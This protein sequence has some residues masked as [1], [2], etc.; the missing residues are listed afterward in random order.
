[1]IAKP[2]VQK[3][4][5]ANP[6]ENLDIQGA[7]VDPF[8]D[9]DD[10]ERR[11]NS[12]H[13]VFDSASTIHG[14]D[15]S[16]ESDDDYALSASAPL[17]REEIDDIAPSAKVSTK[18]I[19]NKLAFSSS[20]V[21]NSPVASVTSSKKRKADQETSGESMA[22]TGKKVKK[23]KKPKSTTKETT[24]SIASV[25]ESAKMEEKAKPVDKD[26]KKTKKSKK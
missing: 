17:E 13:V 5:D 2:V 23:E 26:S 14:G 16:E 9:Q 8:A 6:L 22:V 12:K 19:D 21:K 20:P 15:E 25:S 7:L 4:T 11:I 1:M 3:D 18:T 24:E 10:S